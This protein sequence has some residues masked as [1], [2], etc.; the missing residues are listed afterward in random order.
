MALDRRRGRR[1]RGLP[2]ALVTSNVAL[3]FI[4]FRRHHHAGR[5]QGWN[6]LAGY[7]RTVL[8][9]PRRLL[10]PAAMPWRFFRAAQ[11]WPNPWLALPDR[12]RHRGR[13]W[14]FAIGALSLPGAPQGIVF[15]A[16]HAGLRGGPADPDQCLELHGWRRGR[17]HSAQGRQRQYAVPGPARSV[18]AGARICRRRALPHLRDRPIAFRR[19]IS[20]RYVR[21]RMRARAL[22]S[23]RRRQGS[24]PSPC[25]LC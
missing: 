13:W 11:A 1:A 24:R 19:L 12:G 20:W 18:L 6:I 2:V 3:N 16:C 9:R 8:V 21:T 4:T 10:R 22:V 25:P 5:A 15:C 17:A 14:G 7:G 23:T